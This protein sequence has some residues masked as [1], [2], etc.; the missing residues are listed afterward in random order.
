M[1]HMLRI[2]VM[3]YVLVQYS[4]LPVPWQLHRL[5][6]HSYMTALHALANIHLSL[7]HEKKEAI[8]FHQVTQSSRKLKPNRLQQ[9]GK[10]FKFPHKRRIFV[11]GQNKENLNQIFSRYTKG[12]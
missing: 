1:G 3:L 10:S 6:L 4:S 9:T 8:R 2:S 11:T 7:F 5:R 12:K